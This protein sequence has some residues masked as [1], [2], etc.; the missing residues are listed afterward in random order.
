MTHDCLEVTQAAAV[1]EEIDAERMAQ[2]EQVPIAPVKTFGFELVYRPRKLHPR[3]RLAVE[4]LKHDASF[5]LLLRKKTR[6]LF[7]DRYDA[8]L[9]SIGAVKPNGALHAIQLTPFEFNNFSDLC[10]RVR[11][12]FDNGIKIALRSRNAQSV[13]SFA[14]L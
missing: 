5:L 8:G 14:S 4:I 10:A 2:V 7:R 11:E 6:H 12:K 1:G 13:S 3:K 9:A